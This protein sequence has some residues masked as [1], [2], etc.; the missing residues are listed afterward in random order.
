MIYHPRLVGPVDAMCWTGDNWIAIAEWFYGELAPAA[1]NADTTD[2]DAAYGGGAFPVMPDGGH[3]LSVLTRGRGEVCVHI[4]HW[5][6]RDGPRVMTAD[7]FRAVY[8]V[9]D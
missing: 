9:V 4:G 7:E 1:I 8:T 6:I 5:V 2:D 3:G